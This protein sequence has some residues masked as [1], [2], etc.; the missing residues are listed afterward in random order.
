MPALTRL[1]EPVAI[2]S[3]RLANRIVMPP[4]VT[5]HASELDF[6]HVTRHRRGH[7]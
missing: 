1:F 3:M 4:V 6:V 2:G 7:Q 5:N